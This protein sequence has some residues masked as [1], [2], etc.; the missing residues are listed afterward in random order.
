MDG[1]NQFS[2]IDEDD[3]S[4]GGPEMPR[5][6]VGRRRGWQGEE[7]E[8][9]HQKEAFRSGKD[10]ADTAVAVDIR[11]FQN[12]I[13]GEGYQAKHVVRQRTAQPASELKIQDMSGGANLQR[14]QL[15]GQKSDTG[16]RNY[17]ENSGLR[18]FRKE[19]ESILS[20][21]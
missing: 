14:E 8:L 10:K 16:A 20:S 5:G 13:V 15:K 21:P 6:V 3:G 1:R 11:Q 12:H 2:Q 4:A 18:E 17:I 9:N 19:I 7:L